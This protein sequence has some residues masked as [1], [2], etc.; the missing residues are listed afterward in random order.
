MFAGKPSVKSKSSVFTL[1]NRVDI[2]KELRSPI[3]DPQAVKEGGK[4][5]GNKEHRF[6][7]EDLFRS[8]QYA[9]LSD[10]YLYICVYVW[11]DIPVKV[12]NTHGPIVVLSYP[13]NL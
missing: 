5:K 6:A 2:L 9:F 3:I 8:M 10:V 7:Y 12:I 11:P 13:F 1:G 4:G